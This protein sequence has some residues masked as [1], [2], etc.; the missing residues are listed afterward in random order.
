MQ[1]FLRI[2][3]R[4]IGERSLKLYEYGKTLERESKKLAEWEEKYKAQEI[5]YDEI[6]AKKEAIEKKKREE[7]ILLYLMNHAARVI[8]KFYRNV[9][10]QRRT[11]KKKGKKGGKGKK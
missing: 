10:A 2:Y 3:D 5:I 9:V 4:E 1:D 8:Q 11:K 7:R 6:Q